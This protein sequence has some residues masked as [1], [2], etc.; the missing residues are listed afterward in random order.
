MKID[1]AVNLDL[2]VLLLLIPA[3]TLTSMIGQLPLFALCLLT[4]LWGGFRVY[5]SKYGMLGRMSPA[6]RLQ[7]HVG[8]AKYLIGQIYDDRDG[9]VITL[10]R[11]A[12]EELQEELYF[13]EQPENNS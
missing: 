3:L 12:L 13:S 1:R 5:E 9:V 6:R 2:V 4:V 7:Y 11:A 8:R 10:F